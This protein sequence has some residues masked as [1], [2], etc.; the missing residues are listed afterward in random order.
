MALMGKGRRTIL[1]LSVVLLEASRKVRILR[2]SPNNLHQIWLLL[3]IIAWREMH[4]HWPRSK[5]EIKWNYTEPTRVSPFCISWTRQI[6]WEPLARLCRE[7]P[8]HSTPTARIMLSQLATD[9]PVCNLCKK[10]KSYLL[11]RIPSKRRQALVAPRRT[12]IKWFQAGTIAQTKLTE[13]RTLGA[14]SQDL[15][16]RSGEVCASCP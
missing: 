6:S 9:H 15:W 11:G 3:Q 7:C 10:N 5:M 1:F 14:R 13:V 16:A 2:H 12:K 8:C 4:S